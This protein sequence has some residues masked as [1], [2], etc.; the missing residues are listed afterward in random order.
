MKYL[1]FSADFMEKIKR[2]EKKATLRL[3]I[4]N[5][6]PGE[7]VIVRCGEDE[8]GIAKIYE[9]NIKRF[10]E[11]D[12]IDVLLDGYGSKEELKKAL[13]KFYGKFT[14]DDMFTQIVFDLC[15]IK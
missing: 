14:E 12:E 6:K 11:I 13:E 9:V 10:R 7:K 1:N 3:G 8:I 2:G 15:E 4:K 5:Y